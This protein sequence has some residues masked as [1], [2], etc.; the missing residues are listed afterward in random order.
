MTARRPGPPAYLS[1]R[2]RS[3]WQAVTRGRRATAGQLAL[4]EVGLASLDRAEAARVQ[5]A[6]E[7][8]VVVTGRSGVRHVHPAIKI[9]ADARR[10]VIA[11]WNALRLDGDLDEL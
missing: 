5:I 3:L 8:M 1:D 10:T 4:L 2:S 7:G 9:E 6:S 11:V